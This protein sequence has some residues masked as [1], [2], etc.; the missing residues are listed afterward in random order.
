MSYE[1]RQRYLQR[2]W[3]EELS[4]EANEKA[5][6]FDSEHESEKDEVEESPHQSES[7][8]SA[9]ELEEGQQP[10]SRPESTS[11]LEFP[12]CY[13]KDNITKWYWH[14][15]GVPRKRGQHN[16]LREVPG[17][18]PEIRNLKSIEE[19]WFSFLTDEMLDS[20]VTNTNL[21]IQEKVAANYERERD[22]RET[23]K[24][25]IKALIGLLYLL[26]VCKSSR[27]NI[28]D[29]WSSDGTGVEYFRLTMNQERFRFLL[30]ALRFDDISTREQRK[31]LDKL[32]P[33]R[34]IFENF[35]K[36]CREN[37]RLGEQV[38]ID[39]MLESFRGRCEFRQY[40]R[41]KPAKYGLKI[42]AMVDS[43]CYYTSNLEV[44]VGKQ[45]DPRFATDNRPQAVVLRLIKPISKT[46]RNVTMDNWF[47]SIPLAKELLNDHYLSMVG[48]MRKNKRELPPIVT[49]IKTI[50]SKRPVGSSMFLFT[51]NLTLVSY[52]PKSNKVVLLLSSMHEGDEIHPVTG[53]PSI[54]MDYNTCKG[55]VDT[56]DEMKGSYSVARN[57]R[58]WPL[59]IFFS[60]L[61]IATINSQVIYRF[62]NP[63]ESSISRVQF[64]KSLAKA[65]CYDQLKNRIQIHSISRSIK[66]R[67]QEIGHFE[68]EEQAAGAGPSSAVGR[69]YMC[70][71]KKSS[72]TKKR[73]N[74]CQK[75]ICNKH[76]VF[77]C[78]SCAHFE[79][80]END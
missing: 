23:N 48:T 17:P 20:I 77:Q 78:T 22:A 41:N 25:E 53:K 14:S 21:Y 16:I 54:I 5:D 31:R 65:L 9:D 36:Q 18:V 19:I 37:F 6:Y 11:A 4:R 32:A 2:L 15:D 66:Q 39:E 28:R 35:V 69:C 26:G 46:G 38:T 59:T 67:I 57:S 8:L 45:T 42:F 27:Q 64:I 50:D 49:T 30:R 24:V 70:G 33:I 56:V 80:S 13:G 7:E 47:T 10:L 55:G 72:K 3:D 75:Y 52:I 40:I 34:D 76:V 62:N 74:S 29:A 61:N 12:H 79:D 44:Y 71:T 58:R 68:A 51:E 60:L 63:A 43:S 1:E 73:C